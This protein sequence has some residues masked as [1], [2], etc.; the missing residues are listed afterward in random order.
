ME[1]LIFVAI[2]LLYFF[3]FTFTGGVAGAIHAGGRESRS[4]VKNAGI[5]VVGWIA[6]A[7]IWTATT[8]AWPQEF[9]FGLAGLAVVCSLLFVHLLSKTQSAQIPDS[10]GDQ[11]TVAAGLE[12]GQVKLQASAAIWATV[13]A[14]A[15]LVLMLPLLFLK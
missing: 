14:V 13:A 11:D 6:A 3:V 2:G 10:G 8:G 4:L 9:T 15:V 1:I 7:V 12:G 5:G